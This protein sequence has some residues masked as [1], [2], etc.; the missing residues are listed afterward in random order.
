IGIGS[1][2]Y[3]TFCGAIDKLEAELNNSGAKQTAQTLK[4][5]ILNHDLPDGPAEEWQGT[6]DNLHK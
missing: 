4:I 3:D 5:H 6:W 1:R 2:E